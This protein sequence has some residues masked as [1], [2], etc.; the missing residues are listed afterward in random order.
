[1]RSA[2]AFAS[3]HYQDH[4]DAVAKKA[5]HMERRHEPSQVSTTGTI[6][7]GFCP[8]CHRH[9]EEPTTAQDETEI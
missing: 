6:S 5:K 9:S 3:Q 7:H 4:D 2:E 8:H 1:M